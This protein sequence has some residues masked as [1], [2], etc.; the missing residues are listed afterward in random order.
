M[1]GNLGRVWRS[2]WLWVGIVVLGLVLY[3]QLVSRY[4]IVLSTEVVILALL[5]T[6]YNLIFGYAGMVSFGHAA[7]FGLGAYAMAIL[8]KSYGSPMLLGLLAA[9]VIAAVFAFVIGWFCMRTIRLYFALLSLAFAQLLYVIVFQWVDFTGG[10]DGIHGVPRPEALASYAG[11]YY[12]ALATTIFCMLLMWFIV[13]SPF[14]WSLRA[15]RENTQRS[16]F[17]GINDRFYK[18]IAFTMA[19]AFAGVAGGLYA[20]FQKWADPDLLFWTTS[21]N[22]VLMSIL[23][24]MFSFVGPSIGAGVFVALREIIKVRT[25]YWPLVL[26]LVLLTL[27]LTVPGGIVGFVVEKARPLLASRKGETSPP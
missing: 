17:L 3:P 25:D 19:G 8:T 11:Y 12:F 10:S 7:F 15:I 16:Q 6:S 4:Y 14:G 18:V 27:V 13:N 5:A 26:G 1:A 23:G 2:S 20:Q 22:P 9:P 21:A 24:G